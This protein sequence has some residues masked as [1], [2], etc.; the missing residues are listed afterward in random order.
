MTEL[1]WMCENCEYRDGIE[2]TYGSP[3]C[4]KKNVVPAREKSILDTIKEFV[5]ALAAE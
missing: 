5:E 2:C 1:E 4:P 3:I